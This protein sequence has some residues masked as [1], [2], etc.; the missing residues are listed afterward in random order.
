M[1]SFLIG[2]DFGTTGAKCCIIDDQGDVFA[3]AYREYPI[4]SNKPDWAEHDS[5]LYWEV[6]CQIIQECISKSEI[7]V[8]KIR[9]I[10][11]SSALPSLIMVDES[12]NTIN[13]AYTLL[14]NRA[15][16]EIGYVKDLIGEEKLFEIT[17]NRL[18]DRP[19]VISMLWEKKNRYKDFSR[20]FKVLTVD[21][22]I[23]LRLTGVPSANCSSGVYYGVAYDIRKHQFNKDILKQIGLPP[24][25]F[26][27]FSN[28]DQIIGYTS[29]VAAMHTGLPEGIAVAAGQVDCNAGWLGGGATEVGDMNIN[30]GTCG[31][32]GIIHKSTDFNSSMINVPY[33]TDTDN[34]YVT[35]AS[36]NT[37]GQAL[38]YMRDNFSD[39]E[40]AVEKTTGLNAYQLMDLQAKQVVPG[41]EGL[42][43]LPYFTGERTPIWDLNAK[44]VV[45]GLGLNHTKPHLVRAMMEAVGYALYSSLEILLI[46][47]VIINKP[48]VMNEGGA[49]SLVW[50]KILTDILDIPSVMLENRIGA[51]YGDAILAGVATGVFKDY[52][53]AREKAHYVDYLEPDRENH[54]LYMQYY[55]IYKGLYD[56]IKEDY[57]KLAQ[58]E[59][60]RVMRR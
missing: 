28:C 42:I 59:K 11:T 31:N 14:D 4:I 40:L 24:D 3:Y 46:G 55:E 8:K 30:L 49:K 27:D 54:K 45:F 39:I 21:G 50:R 60:N 25:I 17:G 22:F 26:P 58:I 10:G 7:D 15:K 47:G 12:L 34:T 9:G 52:R 57:I 56:H 37:G 41:S 48:V 23:R 38:R 1:Q 29:K 20:I 13:N 6:A 35:I 32:F 19:I 18:E 36:T 43:V 5:N 16:E 33:T 2:I 51:P 44:G 53:I